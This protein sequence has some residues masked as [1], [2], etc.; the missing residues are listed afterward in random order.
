M[1]EIKALEATA[2]FLICPVSVAHMLIWQR[3]LSFMHV[4]LLNGDLRYCSNIPNSEA[5]KD[6]SYLKKLSTL[7]PYV[8]SS[9]QSSL[10]IKHF[11]NKCLISQV[12]LYHYVSI[13]FQMWPQ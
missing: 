3:S 12:L 7:H 8:L 13:I 5:T 2:H 11:L 4:C 1:K 6:L 10:K 9:A